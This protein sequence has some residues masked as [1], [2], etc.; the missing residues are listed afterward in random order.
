MDD[1][2]DLTFSKSLLLKVLLVSGKTEY[3]NKVFLF[4]Y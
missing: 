4:F 3:V 1:I 2:D